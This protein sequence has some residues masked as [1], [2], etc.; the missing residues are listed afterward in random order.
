MARIKKRG[1]D[2]F[3]LNTDFMHNRL[4]RRIMKREGDGAF[5]ILLGAISCIYA[6]EGYYIHIDDL[7]YEDLAACLYEKNAGDAKRILSLAV[8]YGI[9]DAT[10][11]REY[12]ILTSAE[13]QKQY[14]FSTKRRRY[15]TMVINARYNLIDNT[16]TDGETDDQEN[17]A[18]REAP[19]AENNRISG[20]CNNNIPGD[21]QN[22]ELR[23]ESGNPQAANSTPGTD[24]SNI[25]ENMQSETPEAGNSAVARG[26]EGKVPDYYMDRPLE[27]HS[28]VTEQNSKDVESVTFKPQ[29][30]TSG[31][32][33][34]AQHSIAQ[35][36]EAYPL[37]NGSPGKGTE[38]ADETS[39]EEKYLQKIAGMQPP[40]DGISRNY[41]GLL[42]NLRQLHIAPHEQYAIILKSNFG[43]IGHP[44]WKG[45]YALRDSHGKIR[46]PGRYLLSLC[47]K[48]KF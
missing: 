13:I 14:L 28:G 48:E 10:L 5:A 4:V 27:G 25:P 30:V 23:D 41:D 22:K 21:R 36:S 12:G 24:G 47:R 8:E 3:P 11:F 43:A 46:L 33:S 6:D 19:K 1:L 31:T 40:S 38:V 2:Y 37:L 42:F 44:L 26:K 17:E 29:N 39:A 20:R 15:S 45:F 34:I 9:F 18:D 16:L 32:H 7:F 35:N